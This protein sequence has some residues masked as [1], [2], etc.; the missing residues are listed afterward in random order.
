MAYER[1]FPRKMKVFTH[2]S[3]KCM[4]YS[5]F[6]CIYFIRTARNSKKH[7]LKQVISLLYSHFVF[8][9]LAV[10]EYLVYSLKLLSRRSVNQLVD[11][12]KTRIKG[13]KKQLTSSCKNKG[14]PLYS[15]RKGNIQNIWSLHEKINDSASTS[16]SINYW[17]GRHYRSL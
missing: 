3:I 17:Y 10:R 6:H 5:I 11:L 4:F 13:K 1:I 12:L 2:I 16:C 9:R 15:P 8:G 7:P 14:K